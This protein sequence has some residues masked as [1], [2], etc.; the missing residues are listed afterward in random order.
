MRKVI[1]VVN[2]TLDGYMAGP[3]GELDWMVFDSL[4]NQAVWVELR[5]AVDTILTGRKTY[6]SFEATFREQAANPDSPAGLVDFATWMLDTPKV[7]FS[8]TLSTVATP[9]TRL[10]EADIPD[11]IALLKQQPG[12]GLV[13]FGGASTVQSF[14]QQGLIDEYWIKLHPVAIGKGLPVFT[15][16]K[17]KASLKLVH[18]K[19]YDSGVLTLRY[20]PAWPPAAA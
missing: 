1:L 15:D 9:S 3:A 11:E 6:Q 16:L 14:V 4:M 8:R 18:S 17:H 20:Q 10:A 12:K 19:A 2:T 5:G 13:I 7:V